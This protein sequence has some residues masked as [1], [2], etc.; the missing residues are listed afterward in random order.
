MNYLLRRERSGRFS[1]N[2]SNDN[3]GAD[4]VAVAPLALF[5]EVDPVRGV[6]C[7]LTF[8]VIV[9]VGCLEEVAGIWCGITLVDTCTLVTVEYSVSAKP[10]ALRSATCDV[11]GVFDRETPKIPSGFLGCFEFFREKVDERPFF[12]FTITLDPGLG[13]EIFQAPSVLMIILLFNYSLT[14]KQ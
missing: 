13:T 5:D 6:R 2:V 7:L 12:R 9:D 3:L 10:V 8:F 14:Q 4:S 1:L 11:F